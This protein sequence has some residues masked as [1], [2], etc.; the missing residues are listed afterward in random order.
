MPRGWNIAGNVTDGD[1]FP[2]TVGNV[3]RVIRANSVRV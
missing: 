3:A 2:I 1:M